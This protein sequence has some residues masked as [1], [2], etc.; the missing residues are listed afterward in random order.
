MRICARPTNCAPNR[1][2]SAAAPMRAAARPRAACTT[3]FVVTVKTDVTA[4]KAASNQKAISG[5]IIGRSL[6]PLA[7]LVQERFEVRDQ[8]G[9]RGLASLLED[10]EFLE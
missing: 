6:S 9:R 7:H 1:M 10:R 3:F 4:V 2:K 5:R 8:V